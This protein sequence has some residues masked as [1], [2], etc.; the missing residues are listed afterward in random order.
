LS[1]VQGRENSVL[2]TETKKKRRNGPTS[3]QKNFHA[4]IKNKKGGSKWSKIRIDHEAR[5]GSGSAGG[6]H[7]EWK[8]KI[9]EQGETVER[10][11]RRY[12]EKKTEKKLAGAQCRGHRRKV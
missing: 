9:V 7:C 8:K 10:K 2:A 5:D 4:G 12:T 3:G 11:K 6:R 1:T